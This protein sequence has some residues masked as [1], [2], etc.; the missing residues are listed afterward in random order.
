MADLAGAGS[1]AADFDAALAC[2][3]RNGRVKSP[4]KPEDLN[5]GWPRQ[6]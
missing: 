6:S 1:L 4:G 5:E 2:F 3:A